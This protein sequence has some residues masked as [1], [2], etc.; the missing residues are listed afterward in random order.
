MRN[1]PIMSA[2]L[3]RP[4]LKSA[5]A[6]VR[7]PVS[8]TWV[9]N[10]SGVRLS[11]LASPVLVVVSVCPRPEKKTSAPL[12]VQTL[13]LPV[14]DLTVTATAKACWP[15][16]LPLSSRTVSLPAFRFTTIDLTAEAANVV[17]MPSM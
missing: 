2:R 13:S 1:S 4:S 6:N 15:F 11:S 3:S 16:T 12:A 7:K 17:A 10:Q 14:P 9:S 5:L 8:C